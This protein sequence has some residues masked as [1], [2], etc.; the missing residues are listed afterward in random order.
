MTYRRVLQLFMVEKGSRPPALTF[1][2]LIGFIYMIKQKLFLLNR[3]PF[4]CTR[5]AFGNSF[6]RCFVS[7]QFAT[8]HGF[9]HG[10]EESAWLAVGCYG[11]KYNKKRL[12]PTLNEWILQHS[13]FLMF[14]CSGVVTYLLGGKKTCKDSLIVY[15]IKY[16]LKFDIFQAKK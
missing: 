15:E 2:A 4:T 11:Q 14:C 5:L 12:L 1:T 8:L 10:R 3:F 9:D 13:Y 6:Y 16:K 7:N